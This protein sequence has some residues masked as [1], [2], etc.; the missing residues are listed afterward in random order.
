MNADSPSSWDYNDITVLTSWFVSFIYSQMRLVYLRHHVVYDHVCM[1]GWTNGRMNGQVDLIDRLRQTE[2]VIYIIKYMEPKMGEPQIIHFSQAF[3]PLIIN[4]P[5]WGTPFQETPMY[6]HTH[7]HR[8]NQPGDMAN[9]GTLMTLFPPQ[10]LS[11]EK[12][13]R[14]VKD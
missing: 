12:L 7:K 11:C 9:F 3:F 13:K 5:F 1:D 10:T 14:I 8:A 4:H 6:L 2:N